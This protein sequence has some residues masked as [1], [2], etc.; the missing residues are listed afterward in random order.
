MAFR[1]CVLTVIA[2]LASSGA[3]AAPEAVNIPDGELTLHATLYRPEG[4]GP[5]PAVVALHDCG[6][7]NQR[8]N[9]EAQLYSEWAKNLVDHGFVV[10][11]PDSFGSRALGSQCREGI[12][13]STRRVSASPT[14]SRRGIGSSNRAMCAAIAYRCWAGR[15]V[16]LRRCGQHG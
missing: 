16:Q 14:R 1:L 13:R 8:P 5:F 7:L 9:T 4:P 15:M 2:V 12:A 10:L 3:I 6:G 11:F